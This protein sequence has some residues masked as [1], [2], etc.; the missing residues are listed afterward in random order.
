MS[1]LLLRYSLGKA[2]VI[3]SGIFSSTIAYFKAETPMA[4]TMKYTYHL[5]EMVAVLGPP[6]PEFLKRSEH[7]LR[8]WDETGQ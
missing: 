1:N 4:S 2:D 7:S 8:Y 3:R 6:P 5:A